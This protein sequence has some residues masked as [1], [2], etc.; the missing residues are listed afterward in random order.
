MCVI[1]AR[2]PKLHII[3]WVIYYLVFLHNHRIYRSE[4]SCDWQSRYNQRLGSKRLA[5]YRRHVEHNDTRIDFT[6]I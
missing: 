2:V 5:T 6:T 4:T 1:E 3:A